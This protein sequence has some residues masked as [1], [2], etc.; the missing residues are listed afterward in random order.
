MGEKLLPDDIS[1]AFGCAARARIISII[2]QVVTVIESEFLA[3]RDVAQGDEPD[4]P[5]TDL[6]LA[7][8][9]ARMIDQA[10]RIPWDVAVEILGL[11]KRKYVLVTR[12]TA[13][14]GFA[15]INSFPNVFEDAGAGRNVMSCEHPE[16]VNGR[17]PH[18]KAF[19]RF[20]FHW[21]EVS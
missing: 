19:V 11:A 13:P 17:G 6:S 7:I 3:G 21:L 2:L 8:G 16:A 1:D 5:V 14:D 4:P 15:F 9:S 20:R 18:S 12:G 10:R